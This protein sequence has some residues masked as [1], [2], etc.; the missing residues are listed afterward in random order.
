MDTESS[1]KVRKKFE[2]NPNISV[3]EAARQLEM[4]ASSV[5]QIKADLLGI[6]ARKKIPAP[7]YKENQLVRAK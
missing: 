6:K 5:G 2:N 4:P 7:K 3:R 1:E